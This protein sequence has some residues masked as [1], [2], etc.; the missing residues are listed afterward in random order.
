MMVSEGLTRRIIGLAVEVHR[1]T[2]PGLLE[3]VYEK[4]LCHE[5]REAGIPFERQ[6]GVPI[7]YNSVLLGVGYRADIVVDRQV[8]LEIKTVTEILPAHEAQLLTYLRMSQIPIGLLL[9]FN[10]P[11]LTDGLRRLVI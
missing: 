7:A 5:L 2:G 9:N 10:A 6:V 1:H 3:A 11:R 4:C 8:I